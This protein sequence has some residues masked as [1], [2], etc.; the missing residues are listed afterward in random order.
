[1]A[2]DIVAAMTAQEKL[3][4]LDGD[5]PFWAGL[6][7]LGEAGYHKSP[8]RAARV[9]RLGLPGFAF[10]DGPRGVVIDQAT[11]FPV[12]MAR[13]ATWDID[14]EERIGEAIGRELRAVGADLFGGVCV[15]VLRHPA[16]GRAQETYGEDPH[17]VGEMGSA[18]ARGVQR[19]AMACVKHLACNSMENARF[20]V[21][22]MV[23]EVAL[24][25]VYLPHFRRIVDEGIA[26]VMSAY[27]SVDG[28]WC[29]ESRSLLTDVLRG[30]WGFEGFVISDWIFGIRD[31]AR[32]LH[33]GLDVE[34]PY[35]MIR[36]E[37][38]GSALEEGEV[39]WDEV[40]RAVER[41]VG[42]RLRFDPILNRPAPGRD[43]LACAEHRALAREA[44]ARSV[45][46]LRN[47]PIDGAPLLPLSLP[48]GSSM[49]LLGALATEVNLGDG[50]SSDV[51]APDVVT[52]A[53]GLRAA[54]PECR[55]VVSDGSDLREAASLAASAQV[56]VVVVGYTRLDEGEFIGDTGTSDLTGLFPGEDDP[57]LAERFAAEIADER[58]TEP[59]AHVGPRPDGG[60]FTVGG[61]RRTLRLH[62]DDVALIRATATA[63]PR[64]VVALVAGSAVLI[65]EWDESVPAV[66]QSWYSG[67]EGG[68]G[69]ADVLLGTVDASGRLP[70][71]VPR[72]EAD[73]PEFDLGT[74]AFTYDAWHGYWHLARH[75]ATPAYPF[76]FGLSYTTFALEQ[77]AAAPAGDGIVVTATLRNTGERPGT[78][79]V[80][81]YASRHGSG[82]PSKL[83]GFGRVELASGRTATV[84]L[85]I[86]H[87]GLAER[88]VISHSMEVRPGLYDLRVARHAS[89]EGIALQVELADRA[90]R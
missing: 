6:T 88:E 29:G 87:A 16:W 26:V 61:D 83:V 34:M 37:H 82:R 33:A 58:S 23:D 48:A 14:L 7:Y 46:L 3:W 79:V 40:D 22:I 54:L 70:F 44:A 17:H 47:E 59:P 60:G 42:T 24:H 35:R 4:C 67:M 73:L 52:V 84:D 20:E 27:N 80:Q 55:V 5:A 13:G 72:T 75:G 31:A 85:A 57:D 19:H 2:R 89:D 45:V 49:A 74:R 69:L 64:T 63:N 38:L 90:E 36:A 81:V 12:S 41:V 66:V 76:G 10:S 39:S 77:A 30:E 1:V 71:S 56:A 15:N 28:E 43:V 11:C 9:D 18:L 51:W 25:E 68:H 53:D 8:F 65:S 86:A 21:D 32:S 62:D 78:D 50:G